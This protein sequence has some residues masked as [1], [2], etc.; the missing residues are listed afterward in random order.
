MILGAEID[1]GFLTTVTGVG[2][3]ATVALLAWIVRELYRISSLVS[4]VE[5]RTNDHDRRID[6]LENHK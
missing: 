3:T 6:R 2:I 1:N 5:E 4:K